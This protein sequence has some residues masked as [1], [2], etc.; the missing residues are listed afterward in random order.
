LQ[1]IP[2]L[3]R[4]DVEVRKPFVLIIERQAVIAKNEE[5]LTSAR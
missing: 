1:P 5:T 4:R 3:L 2:E